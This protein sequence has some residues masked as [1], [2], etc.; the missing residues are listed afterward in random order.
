VSSA[1]LGSW[2]LDHLLGLRH[3]GHSCLRPARTADRPAIPP[4]P[5]QPRRSNHE[6]RTRQNGQKFLERDTKASMT[7]AEAVHAFITGVGLR[8]P[9]LDGWNAGRLVLSGEQDWTATDIAVPPVSL[10]S[11]T[12]AA[13]PGCRY[14]WRWPSQ[15]R[16]CAWPNWNWTLYAA[17]SPVPPARARSLAII[18]GW[19]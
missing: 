13:V 2:P 18:V 6:S 7:R 14:A 1:L 19:R 5:R 10:L 17:C 3:R 12:N 8:G 16:R 9:G 4:S 15:K 11:P